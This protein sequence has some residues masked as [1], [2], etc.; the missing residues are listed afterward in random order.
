MFHVRRWSSP[1]AIFKLGFLIYQAAFKVV[2]RLC[3]SIR[4][5]VYWNLS[6]PVCFTQLWADFRFCTT[7]AYILGILLKSVFC[8][9]FFSCLCS[10]VRKASLL[11]KKPLTLDVLTLVVWSQELSTPT[12]FSRFSTDTTAETPSPATLSPVRLYFIWSEEKYTHDKDS[13]WIFF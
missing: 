12:A 5:V 1:K 13:K 2:Q 11:E 8:F 3:F 10:Q 4:L 9:S 7:V 6:S